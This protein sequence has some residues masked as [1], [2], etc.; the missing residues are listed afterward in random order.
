MFS[1]AVT[2]FCID[3]FRS[4]SQDP[5]DTTNVFLIAL[6][7]QLANS[8]SPVAAFSMVD[9]FAARTHDVYTNA[10]YFVSLTLALSV[11]SMCILGKQW[12]REFE[13]D[14]SI[15]ASAA[16]RVRQVRFDSLE[17]W[18]VPEIMAVLPVI[19]LAALLLFFT[20]LLIQLWN[21]SEHT[22]AIAVSIVVALI[23]LIVIVTTIV[24]ALWSMQPRRT[25][26]T[27]FRSPQAWIV[28]VVYRRLQQWYHG[29]LHVYAET[30]ISPAS[31]AAFDMHFLE[32]EAKEWFDNE[33]NSVHRSLQ[34]AYSVL[35]NSSAAEKAVYWCFQI[36]F[37]PED[38]IKSERD[39]SRYV[40][41]GDKEDR[42]FTNPYRLC[43][44]CSERVDGQQGIDSVVGRYQAE[45]YG[46]PITRYN[47]ERN[48]NN[49]MAL[50]TVMGGC[51]GLRS[52]VI[53]HKRTLWIV[54]RSA[55]D[56]FQH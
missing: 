23:T 20:G 47:M 21:A 22:T 6:S 45:S 42:S 19:L 4:L 16:V 3:S 55:S 44:D 2:A 51:S 56:L 5:A 29:I 18:K 1:A 12:I 37:R 11:S 13:K 17:V 8:S 25:A 40:L 10:L 30:P 32:V 27:P 24:P 34:W 35:R 53:T 15:S 28:F 46:L 49:G 33:I 39:L 41:S 9:G 14:V 26:F 54:R 31:W 50:F 43:Y 36:Q 7:Q 48:P 38:L 52:L